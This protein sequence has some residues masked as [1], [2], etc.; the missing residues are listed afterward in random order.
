MTLTS[1]QQLDEIARKL[2]GDSAPRPASPLR[3]AS[4]DG[5]VRMRDAD[6]RAVAA[7][8]ALLVCK[9][10]EFGGCEL[11]IGPARSA[12]EQL[13]G[14]FPDTDRRRLEK[15]SAEILRWLEDSLSLLGD[16]W[17]E[18]ED[19]GIYPWEDREFP[20]E[21][22][23]DLIRDAIDDRADLEI[24]YFTYSRNAFSRRRVT[25]LEIEGKL[26]LRAL[27]HWRR[28]ERHFLLRR[29]KEIRRLGRAGE[30]QAGG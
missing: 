7:V 11:P 22:K 17:E 25:P 27:C 14:S 6:E 18:A 24:E 8:G 13:I 3:F 1:F 4:G 12:L 9:L 5:D 23:I 16:D 26:K 2:L 29:I 30:G 28:G 15:E 21:G 10:I 20:E 19:R